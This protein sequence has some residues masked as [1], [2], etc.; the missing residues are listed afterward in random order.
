MGMGRYHSDG[1]F[2]INTPA[3]V[4]IDELGYM[5]ISLEQANLLFLAVS[6]GY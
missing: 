1:A 5:P 4:I 3:S 2:C 6:T